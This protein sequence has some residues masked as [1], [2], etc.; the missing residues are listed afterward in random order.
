VSAR[1]YSIALSNP[2]RAAAGMLAHARIP[3][4]LVRL[5]AGAHPVLLRAA[6]FRGWTVPALEF[7]NGRRLQG[8]LAISR[9]L[10]E[11]APDRPLF[12]RER[13]A[14]R[15]VEDAESW[16]HSELQPLPRRFIRFGLVRHRALRRWFAAD[17]LGWPAPGLV[18]ELG[19]PTA[20]VMARAVGANEAAVRD[21]VRRLPA[22]LDRVDELIAAGTIGGS[23][24]NAADFQILSTVRCCSSTP[25]SFTSSRAIPPPRPRGASSRAVTG[26]SLSSATG[27][28]A[29][30]RAGCSSLP[31]GAVRPTRCPRPRTG[32]R[33]GP[34]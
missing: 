32:R 22:L 15:A 17:I 9:A 29:S 10:H 20:I 24:P 21:D 18:G 23:E 33:A 13:E 7:E 27:P 31:S 25:T 11:L 34:G 5:P 3:Y 4:R 8:S 19:R 1:L 26:R 16:G 6:G 28:P 2:G 30:S 12:P 14:R